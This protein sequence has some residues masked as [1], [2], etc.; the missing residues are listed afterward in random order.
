MGILQ[1][2]PDLSDFGGINDVYDL[3][4][5][6]GQDHPPT[7]LIV[8]KELQRKIIYQLSPREVILALTLGRIQHNESITTDVNIVDMLVNSNSKHSGFDISRNAFAGGANSC[9]DMCTIYRRGEF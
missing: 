9:I 7:T 2:V 3:G 5:G 1:G 8:K 6:L 4:F